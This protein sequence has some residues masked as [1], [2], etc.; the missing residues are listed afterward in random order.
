MAILL[1]CF[2]SPILAG[3][4]QI[5]PLNP[6]FVEQTDLQTSQLQR[7]PL[8]TQDGHLLG[9]R[10]GPQNLSFLKDISDRQALTLQQV[11]PVSFDLREEG[12]VSQVKN[13]GSFGTCWAFASYASLE[14]CLMP[15]VAYDFSEKHLVNKDGF[16]WGPLDGGNA[17]MSTAYLAQRTGPVKESDDPYHVSQWTSSPSG[18]PVQ[19]HVQQVRLIPGKNTSSDNSVIKQALMDHG[20]IY[21]A[22]RHSN[23]YYNPTHHSYYYDGDSLSNHGVA[24]VGWD[25]SYPATNFEDTAPGDGAYIV[26]NSWGTGWGE[27][28]YFYV[29]YYDTNFAWSIMFQFLDAQ[30]VDTYSTLYAYDPLGWVSSMGAENSSVFWAANIF[31]ATKQEYLS[32]VSFY[33]VAPNTDYEIYVYTGVT[34]GQPRSGNLAQTTSGTSSWAG[35]RTIQI[36]P[37]SLT[38]DEL[39]SIVIRFDTPGYPYPAALEYATDD[40]S[41]QANA[42]PD[43]SFYSFSGSTS[44]DLTSSMPT[45]NFCIKG[46]AAQRDTIL[47]A[48][49]QILLQ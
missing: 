10:P 2:A 47:P 23:S 8:Q 19:K 36:D 28:G 41:S 46:W 49:L 39:F 13:Q 18:L 25:D 42:A 17:F 45:A 26:K 11:F 16:D 29:S 35:Y 38:K 22:Y 48:I 30:P 20:A 44:Y 34:S 14:S 1:V 33:A 15:D 27:G 12:Q 32:A 24:I 3:S 31:S 4:I 40:Y 7:A 9:W 43:Q 21:T 5:A 6:D 37:V